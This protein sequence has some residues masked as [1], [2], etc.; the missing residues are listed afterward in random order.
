MLTDIRSLISRGEYAMWEDCRQAVHI[1][2]A[3]KAPKPPPLNEDIGTAVR[4]RFKRHRKHPAGVSNQNRTVIFS[5]NWNRTETNRKFC[6]HLETE[7]EQNRE[8]KVTGLEKRF[9]ALY[10]MVKEN[11]T[12][13]HPQK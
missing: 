4:R 11:G 12:R 9:S 6:R 5:S 1:Q 8:K 13:G 2:V 3:H 7:P 10:F